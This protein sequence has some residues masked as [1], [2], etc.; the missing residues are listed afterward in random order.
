ML[1]YEFSELDFTMDVK[2]RKIRSMSSSRGSMPWEEKKK[3]KLE[4]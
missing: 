1:D 4:T 3:L 2:R